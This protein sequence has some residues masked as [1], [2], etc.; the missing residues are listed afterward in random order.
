MILRIMHIVIMIYVSFG[1]SCGAVIKRRG[2]SIGHHR[3][4]YNLPQFKHMPIT[5]YFVLGFGERY[6]GIRFGINEEES[7]CIMALKVHFH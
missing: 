4:S 6:D 2:I 7:S 3:H 1:H 5:V